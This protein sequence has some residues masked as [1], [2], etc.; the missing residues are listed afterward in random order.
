MRQLSGDMRTTGSGASGDPPLVG[1]YL[2]ETSTLAFG[3]V[4]AGDSQCN[5]R[6]RCFDL[7]LLYWHICGTLKTYNI[8]LQAMVLSC[9]Q[10]TLF[11]HR[12]GPMLNLSLTTDSF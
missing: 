1:S 7:A 5:E 10:P 11:K 6:S 12:E 4:G 2:K 9:P 8:G 3:R